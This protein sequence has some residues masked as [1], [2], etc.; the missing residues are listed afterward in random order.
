MFKCFSHHYKNGTIETAKCLRKKP[1]K[2]FRSKNALLNLE[3]KKREDNFIKDLR[4]L[5]R[6]K[7][8]INNNVFKDIRNLFRLKKENAAI[9]YRRIIRDIRNVL[10][11]I[12]NQ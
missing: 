10:K 8:E 4:K 1:E 5:F 9:K 11:I 7:K 2:N 12:I 6:L 3:E